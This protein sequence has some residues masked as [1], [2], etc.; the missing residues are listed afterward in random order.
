MYSIF[1]SLFLSLILSIVLNKI[2]CI[3]KSD[4]DYNE[5][6]VKILNKFESFASSQTEK[7]LTRLESVANELNVSSNCMISIEHLLSRA[8]KDEWALKSEI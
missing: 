2:N 8:T 5:K 3:D 7:L 4:N 1:K 6:W